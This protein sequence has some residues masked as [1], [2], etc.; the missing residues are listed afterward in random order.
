MFRRI[1]ILVVTALSFLG[2]PVRADIILTIDITNP[3]SIIFQ[4][5]S[6]FAQNNA[7]ISLFD[8]ITLLGFFSS[9]TSFFDSAFNGMDL[10]YVGDNTNQTLHTISVINYETGGKTDARDLNIYGAIPGDVIFST[11][12]RALNHFA[13]KNF[14][15][16]EPIAPIGTIGNI[17]VGNKASEG[18]YL[19]LGQ[20]Q[21]IPEASTASL[22]ALGSLLW[23][24]CRRRR[25]KAA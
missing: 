21:I 3:N 18:G 5:T 6:A 16:E 7:N 1:W 2:A 24:G 20:F 13:I 22:L 11:D 19:V 8:G 10:I 17:V 23:L 15:G 12:T 25:A 9:P 14:L 4:S